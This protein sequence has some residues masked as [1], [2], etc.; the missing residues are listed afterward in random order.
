MRQSVEYILTGAH[1]SA[2][3]SVVRTELAHFLALEPTQEAADALLARM[4][5][6]A[7]RQ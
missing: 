6:E 2:L 1:V 3:T 7:P 4:R 5:R